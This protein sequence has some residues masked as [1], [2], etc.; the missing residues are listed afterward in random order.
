MKCLMRAGPQF[1]LLLRLRSYAN[2]QDIFP[3][4]FN[5]VAKGRLFIPFSAVSPTI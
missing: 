4:E 3:R 1:D 5:L 2:N